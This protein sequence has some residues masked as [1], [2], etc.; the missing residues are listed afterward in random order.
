MVVVHVSVGYEAVDVL[1]PLPDAHKYSGAD[2][3]SSAE[4][5]E[6]DWPELWYWAVASVR[7]LVRLDWAARSLAELVTP[8]K[9]GIAMAK[10]IAMM[11]RTTM[12]SIRV[13]PASADPSPSSS[14][15]LL[16]RNRRSAR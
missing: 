14:A 8:R 1:V 15:V 10:R 11:S 16:S 4:I 13:K 9:V 5:P 12:S 7:A 2:E 6:Y 3:L